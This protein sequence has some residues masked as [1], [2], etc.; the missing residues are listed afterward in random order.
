MND[1][2]IE[3]AYKAKP[4][5]FKII[6]YHVFVTII[7]PDLMIAE[8]SVVLQNGKNADGGNPTTGTLIDCVSA[9]DYFFSFFCP[10]VRK[11]SICFAADRSNTTALASGK[12]TPS[13]S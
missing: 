4:D 2:I 13:I 1:K 10:V 8:N 12:Y 5:M 11:G 7:P 9:E 3:R 6:Y